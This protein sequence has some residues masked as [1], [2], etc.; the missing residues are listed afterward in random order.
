MNSHPSN[1]ARRSF[2]LLA[3]AVWISFVLHRTFRIWFD[4][5]TVRFFV[6]PRPGRYRWLEPWLSGWVDLSD[7]G[8]TAAS[9]T[10]RPLMTWS[11]QLESI[12]FGPWAPGY[13]L[14]NFAAHLSCAW[15]LFRFLHRR[16]IDFRAACLGAMIFALHPVTTQP[17][18]ILVDRAEVF[19][20]LGGL[21]A[22]NTYRSRPVIAVSGTFLALLC[23][24]TAVTIPLWLAACDLLMP[25]LPTIPTTPAQPRRTQ[26][27]RY[28]Q[29][30]RRIAP[31]IAITTAYVVYRSIVFSGLGGYRSLDHTRL[32]HLPDVLSQNIAWLLTIPHSRSITAALLLILLASIPFAPRMSRF[33]ILWFCIFLLPVHNLCNKWYLYTPAAALATGLAAWCDAGFRRPRSSNRSQHSSCC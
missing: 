22:L 8:I 15:L 3:A 20:L 11:F 33:G 26:R 21:I 13:H 14:L 4:W 28:I 25:D 31:H 10:L 7:Y 9:L 30:L 2:L 32:Y 6:I 16:G 18:W 23:K 27:S 17:L 29:L 12:L 24:E 1:N 5:E 19:V